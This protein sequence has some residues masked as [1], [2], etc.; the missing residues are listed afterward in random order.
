MAGDGAAVLPVSIDGSPNSLQISQSGERFSVRWESAIGHHLP[1]GAC[2][3]C[4]YPAVQLGKDQTFR[5]AAALEEGEL[6]EL[7]LALSENAGAMS[8]RSVH[9]STPVL[10]LLV[11]NTD[12]SIDLA[13]RMCERCPRLVFDTFRFCDDGRRC[14]YEGETALIVLAANSRFD[15]L[16]RMLRLIAAQVESGA[17]ADAEVVR[18]LTAHPSGPFFQDKKINEIIV[19]HTPK[20][21][22]KRPLTQHKYDA[23]DGSLCASIVI[24]TYVVL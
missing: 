14:D 11:R 20:D 21:Q 3:I 13:L 1:P 18:L 23:F 15:P 5:M 12:A 24:M 10:A 19:Y 17:F 8:I 4:Q 22:I 9:G 2:D 7:L 6:A 16:L